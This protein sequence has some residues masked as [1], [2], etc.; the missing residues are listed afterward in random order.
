MWSLCPVLPQS[1]GNILETTADD[2]EDRNEENETD[3]DEEMD[4]EQLMRI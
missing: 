2:L 4:F 1:L 3:K